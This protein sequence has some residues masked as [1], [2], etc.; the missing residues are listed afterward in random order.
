[1]IPNNILNDIENRGQKLYEIILISEEN[2]TLATYAKLYYIKG[3]KEQYEIDNK[4]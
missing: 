2:R 3:C 4:Q 1:M